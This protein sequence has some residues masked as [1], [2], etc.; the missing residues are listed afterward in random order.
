MEKL[1]ISDFK[2]SLRKYPYIDFK[3]EREIGNDILI[4]ENLTKEG[5]FKNLS[6][7]VQKNEKI[8]I[9]CDKSTTITMLYDILTGKEQADGGRVTWG[10]TISTRISAKHN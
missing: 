9:L 1:T 10:K 8:G 4:V 5:Y 2:P 6:F 7:S 3:F